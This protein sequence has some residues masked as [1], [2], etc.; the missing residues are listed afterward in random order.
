ME[1]LVMW[2]AII[3]GAFLAMSCSCLQESHRSHRLRP[4][5]HGAYLHHGG[6]YLEYRLPSGGHRDLEGSGMDYYDPE[7]RDNQ[8]PYPLPQD[9]QIDE[10][11][12]LRE[13]PNTYTVL[14]NVASS[15]TIYILKHDDS[16][17]MS[18]VVK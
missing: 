2:D 9:Q 4:P 14:V 7:G 6:P 15:N 16:M 13:S 12:D 10:Q 17:A 5:P 1:L 8:V 3:S 18:S 11:M